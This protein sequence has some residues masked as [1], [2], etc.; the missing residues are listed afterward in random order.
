VDLMNESAG[1]DGADSRT[2]RVAG[3]QVLK[4]SDGGADLRSRVAHW[5]AVLV[6]GAR[7]ELRFTDDDRNVVAVD[8]HSKDISELSTPREQSA[9]LVKGQ[10]NRPRTAPADLLTCEQ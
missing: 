8:S 4:A 10:D 6:H 1:E 3:S 7:A 5:T 2:E 9:V